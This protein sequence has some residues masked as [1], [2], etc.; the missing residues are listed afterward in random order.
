MESGFV[1]VLLVVLVVLGASAVGVCVMFVSGSQ[2][3]SESEQPAA[4]TAHD[5]PSPR[6]SQPLPEAPPGIPDISKKTPPEQPPGEGPTPP[7]AAPKGIA[8]GEL[9][10]IEDFDPLLGER[11][12]EAAIAEGSPNIRSVSRTPEEASRNRDME[13]IEDQVDKMRKGL[14]KKANK[15]ATKMKLDERARE[16]LVDISLE[17]LNQAAEI[18]KQF[19]GTAMTDA[20]RVYMKDQI[21]AANTG[22]ADRIRYLLGDDG[23][24]QFKKESRYYDNPNARVLDE[25]KSIKQQN[26][27]LQKKIEQQNKRNKKSK[28]PGRRQLPWRPR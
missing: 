12:D 3:H 1:K 25:V 26:R 19:A 17:G 15:I 2:I 18:R 4:R 6:K 22:T 9:P 24:K 10:P 8:E 21:R 14:A 23:F 28:P 16:D 13:R 20:D 11:F 27:N 5:S 7:S